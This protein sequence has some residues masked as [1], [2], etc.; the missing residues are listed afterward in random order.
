MT[1]V[2]ILTKGNCVRFLEQHPKNI[3]PAAIIPVDKAETAA[4]ST[5]DGQMNIEALAVLYDE[6]YP[7]VYRYIA[8]R[9]GDKESA[10]DLTSE[11]YSRFL[12]VNDQGNCP[13]KSPKSWLYRA[14]HN[15]I[16]DYF[17]RQK[18]RQH[19]ELDENILQSDAAPETAAEDQ[20]LAD[21]AREALTL[22]TPDQQQVITLRFL[23]GMSIAEVAEIVEKPA[24]AVKSLQ[25]RGLR[26]LQRRLIHTD[27][28]VLT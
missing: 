12:R 13:V 11:V 17:R 3:E 28:G 5:I 6:T 15:V 23:E 7:L 19:L 10:R 14:A 20:I 26:T 27:E 24:G 22:L 9:V 4:K 8:R 16:I 21:S 1:Y 2:T 25:H 18:H